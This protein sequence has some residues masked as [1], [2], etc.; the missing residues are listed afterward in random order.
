MKSGDVKNHHQTPSL[1]TINSSCT[2]EECQ[3]VY[4]F[5]M[6]L[7]QVLYLTFDLFSEWHSKPSGILVE[8]TVSRT[9]TLLSN[10]AGQCHCF[11]GM[12]GPGPSLLHAEI[13]YGKTICKYNPLIIYVR[14]NHS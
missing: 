3:C 10:F 12:E 11:S 8:E 13:L 4:H 2:S 14:N 1:D 9:K 6:C 5:I 7:V